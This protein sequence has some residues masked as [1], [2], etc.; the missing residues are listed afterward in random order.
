MASEHSSDGLHISSKTFCPDKSI[1][2]LDN[3]NSTGLPAAKSLFTLD[4]LLC[5]V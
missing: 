1:V 5:C 3:G 2:I 4:I